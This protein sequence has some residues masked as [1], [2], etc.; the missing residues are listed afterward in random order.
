ML[1]L[2]PLRQRAIE[3]R[4]LIETITKTE[5][6]IAALRRFAALPSE[7]VAAVKEE[8][9]A[10]ARRAYDALEGNAAQVADALQ[11]GVDRAKGDADAAD[12]QEI[13][14]EVDPDRE[15]AGAAS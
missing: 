7:I 14:N 10:T 2:D 12:W 15:T 11:R 13:R 1:T 9:F 4:K 5:A 3:R 6:Q 8:S